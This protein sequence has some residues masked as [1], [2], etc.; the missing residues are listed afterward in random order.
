MPVHMETPKWLMSCVERNRFTILDPVREVRGESPKHG[1]ALR[2]SRNEFT[3]KDDQFLVAW[4]AVHFGHSMAGR[5]GN[6]AYQDMV[7]TAEYRKWSRGHTWQSWRER[8]KNKKSH[9]DPLVEAYL[10]KHGTA[11]LGGTSDD[12]QAQVKHEGSQDKKLTSQATVKH[13]LQDDTTASDDL[14]PSLNEVRVTGT[15][16]DKLLALEEVQLEEGGSTTDQPVRSQTG[17]NKRAKIDAGFEPC[18]PE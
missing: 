11:D 14:L 1:R 12:E 18:T 16:G 6:R 4:I 9:L 13:R 17:A 8:Y 3:K 15:K 2:K 7:G 10:L 5:Q